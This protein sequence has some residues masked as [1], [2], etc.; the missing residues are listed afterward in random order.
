MTKGTRVA[1]RSGQEGPGTGSIWDAVGGA[2]SFREARGRS[3]IRPYEVLFDTDRWRPATRAEAEQTLARGWVTDDARTVSLQP[4]IAWDEVLADHRSLHF[5]LHSWAPLGPLLT[6]FDHTRELRFLRSAMDVA[7]DWIRRHPTIDETSPFAWYDMAIGL[8]AVRLGYLADVAARTPSCPD[9]VLESLVAGIL[10]HAEALAD[11]S[12]F[13][14]HSNHGF[15]FAAGQ[16]ALAERFPEL[17]GMDAARSQARDRLDRLMREHFTVEGVH[18]EHSPKYHWMVLRTVLGLRAAGLLSSQEH[19]GLL[20]RAQEAFAWFV[21]PNGRLVMFGDT[22]H[23]LVTGVERDD[24][25]NE[26]LL[27]VLTDGREGKPPSETLRAFPASGYVVVRDEWTPEGE[28]GAGSYLAQTSAFHSRTHKHADDLS[29]VWYDRG[30][31]I[32]T[33]AGG[34]GYAG[35]TEPGSELWKDG[36]WYADP[37]RIYVESTAAHN[38]VQIDD[39]N[40]PRRTVEPYGSALMRWAERGGVYSA[41]AGVRHWD[42]ICHRRALLFRPSEWLV[43]FDWL[44]DE[45]TRPHRFTQR[46]HFAPEVEVEATSDGR[47]VAELPSLEERLHVV[48]LVRAEVETPVKGRAEPDLLGW[49]SRQRGSM[50]P[51][52]ST[53]FSVTDLPQHAFATLFAF[54]SEPP[55]PSAGRTVHD[56]DAPRFR[57]RWS[58]DGRIHAVVFSRGT[59]G[60]LDLDYRVALSPGEIG[61]GGP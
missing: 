11:E 38:T 21:L 28:G 18:R 25:T 9:P 37:K 10:L 17:P 32:L 58:Q 1:P 31:E 16:A 22:E 55:R 27:F 59:R 40:L 24:I 3:R 30:H 47:L 44:W 49:I 6:A 60:P 56:P 43:V 36:F 51:C 7:L 39:R 20:E 48:S 13:P 5:Q 14:A 33:D 35:K 50:L 29:F 2:A 57:I 46:F 45:E 41:E 15:Y 52:W 34:Y 54:G 26:N 53:G 8:R 4:P 42:T 61:G 19:R 12:L 23:R